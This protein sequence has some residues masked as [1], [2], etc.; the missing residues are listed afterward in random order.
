MPLIGIPADK[1]I[2]VLK[3]QTCRPQVERSG[4]RLLSAGDIMMLA[5]HGGVVAIELQDC[6]NRGGRAGNFSII[7]WVACIA[8]RQI[9]RSHIMGI[10]PRKKR[11]PGGRAHRGSVK[12]RVAE[13][14]RRETIKVRRGHR[15]AER[16]GRAEADIVRHDEQHIGRASR[17]LHGRCIVRSGGLVG[18]ADL[19]PEGAGLDGQDATVGVRRTLPGGSARSG[20]L[21]QGWAHHCGE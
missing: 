2:E 7:A 17:S 15:P 5:D 9:S 1:S 10:A 12:A 21:C 20:C 4:G 16:T 14:A 19:P 11:R 3:A 13:A 6:G 18:R 8:V